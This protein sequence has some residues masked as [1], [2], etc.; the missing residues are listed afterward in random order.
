MTIKTLHDAELALAP[1]VPLVKQ[2]T[3]KDT[4]LDRIV[5]LM[6]L[7]GNPEAQLRAIHIAGT[8]GKT[9]TS[10]YISALLIAA[11]QK[12]GLTVSPHVDALNERV[13]IN[14]QPLPEAE[15]CRLLEKFLHII[16][17]VEQQ[18]SYFELLYAFALWVFCK[19]D[20]DYAVVETGLGGLFDAT[21]IMSREDKVCVITDIGFDHIGILG[22]TLAAITAQK[23]G[24]VHKHNAVIMYEQNKEIM[25]VVRS[26]VAKQQATLIIAEPTIEDGDF[27]ATVAVVQRRN[28]WLA[29][30]AYELIANRDSLPHLTRQVLHQTQLT[31]IPGRLDTVQIGSKA[32]V[33]DGAHNAQKMAAFVSSFQALYPRIK[34]AVL[35][36]LKSDKDYAQVVPE[37]AK[38][39]SSIIITTFHTSQDLPV[40][41]VAPELLLKACRDYDF[42]KVKIIANQHDAFSALLEDSQPIVVVTGSFYLL[43]QLRHTKHYHDSTDSRH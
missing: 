12:V 10:Y 38:L 17:P 28:W 4:T 39:A 34:P 26:W 11:G 33:M 25:T 24:I 23:I 19:Y 2:L 37:L 22:N 30:H 41:S 36:A 14:G 13:Q 3:G 29:A 35:V 1:Y 42:T 6:K 9:S 8:S 7:L 40:V 32:V 18:P 20:V 21:N 5:P 27:I 43:G 31:Y 15:F 16:K